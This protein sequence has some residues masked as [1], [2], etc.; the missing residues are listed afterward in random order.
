MKKTSL[1]TLLVVL[2]AAVVVTTPILAHSGGEGAGN[3]EI[4]CAGTSKHTTGSAV[5][6]M[7]GSPMSPTPGQQV[8]V[9][10]N[11]TGGATVG[12]LYGVMIISALSGSSLPSVDGWVIVTDPSG[13]AANNYYE[14][15][16]TAG[17]NSF[18]WTLTA[19]ASGGHTLYSKAYYSGAGSSSA[20]I[21][22]QGLTFT[23]NAVTPVAPTVVINAP[24]AS[25]TQSGT[26]MSVTATVT[27]GSSA[28][29]TVTLTVD[30]TA[31][32]PAQSVTNPSWTV[33]T[34][35]FSNGSRSLVVSATSADGTG[36]ATVAANFVNPGPT[37]TLTSPTSGS[38]VSGTITVSLTATSLPGSTMGSVSI[39]VDSGTPIPLPS[40]YSYQLDTTGLT[41]GAHILTATGTDN[42]GR[43][44]LTQ[45]SFT[46]A[47][48]GPSVLILQ[49]ADGASLTGNVTVNSTVTL[50][51]MSSPIT[52]AVFSVDGVPIQTKTTSP[53]DFALDTS[54]YSNEIHTLTVMA[55]DA[56]SNSGSHTITVTISNGVVVTNP[57]SVQISSPSDGQVLTGTISVNATVTAGTNAVNFVTMSVDG[58]IVGNKT[59]GPFVFELDTSP[60]MNGSHIINVTAYDTMDLMG[61]RSLSATFA[62]ATTSPPMLSPLQIVQQTG[63][64][65]VSVSVTGSV[66]NVTLAV[67]GTVVRYKTVAPFSF[68]ID[69]TVLT[70]GQHTLNLTATGPGGITSA[71]TT[72]TVSH[73]AQQPVSSNLSRW[74]ATIIGGSLLLMGGVVFMVA[75]VLMLRRSKM[76]RVK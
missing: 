20:T 73:G 15:A 57:P 58:T 51:P 9:W 53:Y 38:T 35:L 31:I 68:I 24:A 67:D 26:A 34:T 11:V 43:I 32:S 5:V 36:S 69:T 7:A 47:N 13:T 74:E 18:M 1:L 64:T 66:T 49:P 37:V 19:P 25:S 29:Q 8:T 40:P 28:L 70:D 52:Q 27:P 76:R 45:T 3:Q 50:G 12:R 62:N 21:F 61:S 30:G 17:Q 4:G 14:R 44:D 59:V 41:N 42:L 16:A 39:R 10:V 60:Y 23:V 55:T 33:D 22:T 71:E 46:V 56:N 63:S 48:Q 75:S 2:V 6:T 54:Q 65:E 72:I